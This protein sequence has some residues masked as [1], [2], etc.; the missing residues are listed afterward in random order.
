MLIFETLPASPLKDETRKGLGMFSRLPRHRREH[1]HLC[2]HSNT[3]T[4]GLSNP[5]TRPGNKG[6]N[7]PFIL[8]IFLSIFL[9]PQA[10]YGHI[11]KWTEAADFLL[12]ERNQEKKKNTKNPTTVW[13]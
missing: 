8:Y 9:P 10:F 11:S 2:M 1:T 7:S 4:Q 12:L 6:R 13:F 3:A 5:Y